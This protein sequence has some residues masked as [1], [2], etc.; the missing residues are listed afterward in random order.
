[1][2]ACVC[3]A[4]P[5][6]TPCRGP[7]RAIGRC[8]RAARH[9]AFA[10]LMLGDA[11]NRGYQG[12][13]ARGRRAPATPGG[14]AT[15]CGSPPAPSPAFRPS[16]RDGARRARPRAPAVARRAEACDLARLPTSSRR[17]EIRHTAPVRA[18]L[19]APDFSANTHA[20]F[21]PKL[22]EVVAMVK[23]RDLNARSQGAESVEI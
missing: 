2:C 8:P 19:R 13:R 21:R 12:A 5:A 23:A 20:R 17:R 6:M 3:V 7:S 1:V 14:P 9:T 10:E 11:E 18:R 4:R 22:E 16:S 15:R